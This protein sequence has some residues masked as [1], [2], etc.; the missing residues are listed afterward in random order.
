MWNLGEGVNW[1]LEKNKTKDKKQAP[2]TFP[3]AAWWTLHCKQ[4]PIYVS[5]E[6]KL[7]GLVP[8]FHIHVSVGDVYR[9][10]D[11]GNR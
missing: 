11:R 5:S 2:I 7:C 4:D 6:M 8:I 9:W 10:T 3:Y 1:T